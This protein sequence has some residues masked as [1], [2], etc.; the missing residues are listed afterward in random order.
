M[1]AGTVLRMPA[2][3][4]LDLLV[5]PATVTSL[6]IEGGKRQRH[7]VRRRLRGR[8]SSSFAGPEFDVLDAAVGPMPSWASGPFDVEGAQ[9]LDRLIRVVDGLPRLAD[10]INGAAFPFVELRS[11]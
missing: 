4:R 3:G 10:T 2:G 9:V 8:R 5:A 6:A 7:H 1:P 11:S